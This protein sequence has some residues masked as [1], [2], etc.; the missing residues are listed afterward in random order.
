MGSFTLQ[1]C[2]IHSLMCMVTGECGP[3][4][5]EKKKILA[6]HFDEGDGFGD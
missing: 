6:M 1:I 5:N 3:E 4:R 2:A